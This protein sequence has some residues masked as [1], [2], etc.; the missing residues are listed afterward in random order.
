MAGKN[1]NEVVI[2]RSGTIWVADVGSTAP[3]DEAASPSASWT[4]VGH[5]SE[6]GLKFRDGA[7]KF[8]VGAWA[9]QYPIVEDVDNRE[10]SFDFILRQWNAKTVVVAFGGGTVSTVTSG[11]YKYVP[12]AASDGLAQ[13]AFLVDWTKGAY[14]YRLVVPK[15]ALAD[16][17]ETQLVRNAAA[18]LPLKFDVIGSD[19]ADP[20]YVLTDDP[21]FS[22]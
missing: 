6:D 5:V 10:A 2:A 1:V 7:N 18:D 12:P 17:V 13:W 4:D 14:K 9:S 11:H 20:Y 19:S 16:Q 8:T 22:T 3:A 21:A 15:S